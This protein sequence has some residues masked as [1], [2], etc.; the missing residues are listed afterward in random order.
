MKVEYTVKH[1]SAVMVCPKTYS[2]L[3]YEDDKAKTAL[4][5]VSHR[6]NTVRH[7]H[8]LDA[9]YKGVTTQT[10]ENS[11]RIKKAA[12]KSVQTVRNAINPL[13]TKL[14]LSDNLVD[15]KPLHTVDDNGD[16]IFV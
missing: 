4:K 6:N 14:R 7:D 3:N 2:L 1:G 12:V 5:G 10:V 16:E 15:I 13:V 8:L 11:F 9:V